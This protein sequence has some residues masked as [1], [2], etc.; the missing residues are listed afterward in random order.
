MTRYEA[1][2]LLGLT[3]S[4]SYKDYQKAYRIVVKQNHPDMGGDAATMVKINQAKDTLEYY[5]G[6]DKSQVFTCAT[7]QGASAAEQSA[8][9]SAYY[10]QESAEQIKQTQENLWRR[11]GFSFV[12]EDYTSKPQAEWT[13]EDWDA[14]RSFKM[15]TSYKDDRSAFN[16][17][18]PRAPK[19]DDPKVWY[20]EIDNLDTDKWT[21]EDWFFYLYANSLARAA[22]FDSD[23]LFAFTVLYGNQAYR[24]YSPASDGR[25]L[26]M[27]KRSCHLHGPY[28][29]R[30]QARLESNYV[31]KQKGYWT[32]HTEPGCFIETPYGFAQMTTTS[33]LDD[34]EGAIN[35]PFAYS[36]TDDYE[37]WRSRN[38]EAWRK[39][40]KDRKPREQKKNPLVEPPADWTGK[41]F[42]RPT[43]YDL[44]WVIKASFF[45]KEQ[46]EQT[47]A[48][49][50]KQWEKVHNKWDK[51][52]AQRSLDT[53]PD[54][55]QSTWIAQ[56][57]GLASWI[58]V[59]IVYSF[60]PSLSAALC[61]G[62]FGSVET[63]MV[64][65]F[66]IQIAGLVAAIVF[67]KRVVR[68]LR[69]IQRRV[70]GKV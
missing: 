41:E 34:W 59:A 24:E 43:D 55:A 69:K 52:E 45:T 18:I 42:I 58:F 7:S 64:P 44:P 16:H 8:E 63:A 20:W 1:E 6:D 22:G 35:V 47:Q 67:R 48:A 54:L 38:L 12:D 49:Y 66:A 31:K 3:G 53:N 37:S 28:W 56:H 70:F 65:T 33:G 36:D 61:M 23:T 39:A 19:D 14:F 60:L 57:Q 32:K 30:E 46:T 25:V 62:L 11:M 29:E 9:E 5:F 27:R 26:V 50:A 13:Q 10:E 15:P 21:Q 4:Y 2:A 51:A 17:W 40:D 68:W